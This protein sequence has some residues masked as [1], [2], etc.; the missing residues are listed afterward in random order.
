MRIDLSN[1]QKMILWLKDILYLNATSSSASR[2]LVRRGQVYQC[3]F[4]IG[5]GSEMQKNRPALI[6]QN[7]P[8]NSHSGNTIV[9]PITHDTSSLPCTVNITPI[10]DDNSGATILDGQANT[11]NIMCVSKARLGDL[12]CTLKTSDMKLIDEAIAKSLDLM[13]Y[14]AETQTKLEKKLLYLAEVKN[15]RNIAQDELKAIREYLLI[16]KNESIID[17]IKQLHNC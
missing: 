12:I 14:Y 1:T 17:A 4:G 5:V 16:S 15:Q 10:T 3:N 7:N 8:A 9:I 6:V 2:R 13:K 11:S